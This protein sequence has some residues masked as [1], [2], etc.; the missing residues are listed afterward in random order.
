VTVQ[1]LSVSLGELEE[2][3]RIFGLRLAPFEE[4][5]ALWARVLDASRRIQEALGDPVDLVGDVLGAPPL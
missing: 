2:V 3:A 4:P 1:R 5:R